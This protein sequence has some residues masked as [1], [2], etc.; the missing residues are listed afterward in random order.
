MPA[1][2]YMLSTILATR[3]LPVV[4]GFPNTQLQTDIQSCVLLSRTFLMTM[5][6][7]GTGFVVSIPSHGLSLGALNYA[8]AG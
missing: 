5:D 1:C 4:H 2:L 6:R 8:I 3:I 7:L